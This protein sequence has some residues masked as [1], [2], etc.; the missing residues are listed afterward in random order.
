MIPNPI[1]YLGNLLVPPH[2]DQ[3]A[4]RAVHVAHISASAAPLHEE[5]MKAQGVRHAAVDE[6]DLLNR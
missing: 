1:S 2:V 5:P 3:P 4:Q 6:V